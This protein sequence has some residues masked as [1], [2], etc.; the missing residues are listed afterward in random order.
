MK[1]ADSRDKEA[2]RLE[3]AE[4]PAKLVRAG[5]VP[6]RPQRIDSAPADRGRKPRRPQRAAL[7][8]LAAASGPAP[9]V[10]LL[11]VPPVVSELPLVLA[12]EGEVVLEPA[13]ASSRFWQAVSDANAIKA[14]VLAWAIL[15][16]FMAFLQG[17][18]A[19]VDRRP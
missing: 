5:Q 18:S 9:D 16:A 8:P 7:A 17:G 2:G 13:V 19:E 10:P 1:D 12:V 11:D 15:R 14:M 6:R 3:Y 4:L